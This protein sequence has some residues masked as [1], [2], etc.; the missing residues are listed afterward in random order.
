MDPQGIC[1]ILSFKTIKKL[2]PIT[3]ES[4]P[5]DGGGAALQVHTPRGTVNFRPCKKG[6]HYFDMSKKENKDLVFAQSP[7]ATIM[8]NIEGFT[9][10]EVQRAIHAR[11]LQSML[12]G[13]RKADY[14]GMVH[15]KMIDDCPIV[16]DI[17][18]AHSIFGP[19]MV[20]LRGRTTQKRPEH[21]E[22]KIVDIPKNIVA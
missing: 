7:I 22:I 21:V 8:S 11:K 2:Y 17:K 1:N 3:Y 18:N 20:G 13:P 10:R 6:L 19:D 5:G 12:R 14:E 16:D 15:A 4:H 9:K